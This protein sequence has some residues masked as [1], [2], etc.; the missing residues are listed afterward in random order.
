MGM[1]AAKD[2]TVEHFGHGHVRGVDRRAA[3]AVVAVDPRQGLAHYC[4]LLPGFG[5]HK[6]LR[7]LR[8]R[9]TLYVVI[10][11]FV[12]VHDPP[13]KEKISRSK[14]MSSRAKPQRAPGGAQTSS[15]RKGSML[16]LRLC[17]FARKPV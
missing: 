11:F 13:R 15:N 7:R 1:G 12:L 14:S 4:C 6:R 3:H 17:V 5:S 9:N 8:H 10:F 2:S 16:S